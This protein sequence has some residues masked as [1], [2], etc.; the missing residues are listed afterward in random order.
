[1]HY[2]AKEWCPNPFPPCELLTVPLMAVPTSIPTLFPPPSLGNRFG[3]HPTKVI[4]AP[5]SFFWF[6]VVCRQSIWFAFAEA[7]C[8]E[9]K[10]SRPWKGN[11]DLTQWCGVGFDALEFCTPICSFFLLSFIFCHRCFWR[12]A[13]WTLKQRAHCTCPPNP[14]CPSAGEPAPWFASRCFHHDPPI[15]CFL[16]PAPWHL[17]AQPKA[18]FL[19]TLNGQGMRTE[20][21][22]LLFCIDDC[23]LRSSPDSEVLCCALHGAT[24]H[25]H[26][27]PFK[28]CAVCFCDERNKRKFPSLHF[29]LSVSAANG[30]FHHSLF[31]CGY[32]V[33]GGKE[34]IVYFCLMQKPPVWSMVVQFHASCWFWPT[35]CVL[36]AFE[37]NKS[38][39]QCYW[40]KVLEVVVFFFKFLNNNKSGG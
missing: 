18:W 11:Q 17:L 2:C 9:L 25:L 34:E 21:A 4:F 38:Q 32:C 23:R 8:K 40:G 3:L 39:Y 29:L 14:S 35:C 20:E 33:P 7:L 37:G 36:Q 5:K 13:W 1:M 16:Y 28:Q 31:L 10:L 6:A 19:L 12:C 24:L 30:T 15:F 22:P 26:C 27:S